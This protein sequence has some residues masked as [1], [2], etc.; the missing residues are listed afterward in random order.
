MDTSEL[1]FQHCK[2]L[3]L[4]LKHTDELYGAMND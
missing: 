4:G 1:T 3:L 2:Y